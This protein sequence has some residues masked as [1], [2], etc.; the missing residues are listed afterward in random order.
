MLRDNLLQFTF[1]M[2][3][4]QCLNIQTEFNISSFYIKDAQTCIW[5]PPSENVYKSK[6]V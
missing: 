6:A 4:I 3:N 1:C 2:M 5:Y